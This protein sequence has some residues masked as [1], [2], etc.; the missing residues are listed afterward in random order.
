LQ[1]SNQPQ[2]SERAI[3][4][5]SFSPSDEPFVL[6]LYA[7]TR[8][9][10]MAMVPWS[11]E[12]RRMFVETQ[13]KAQLDHYQHS[14]P[15]ATHDVILKNDQPVGRVYVERLQNEISILDITVLPKQRNAGIGSHLIRVMLEEA[16]RE[17]KNVGIY[18]ESF[19]P[20]CE[21]FKSRGF[22][23]AEVDGFQIHFL[24][25]PPG[26]AQADNLKDVEKSSAIE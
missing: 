9:D 24:W 15:D 17:N 11:D 19:N 6:E 22:V 23:E 7:S 5:R 13:F 16:T 3:T 2:G 4:L 12:Q 14:F 1:A 25:Y 20:S 26:S 10:E 21:F 8:S 18:I